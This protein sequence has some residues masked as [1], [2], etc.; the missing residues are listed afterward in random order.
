MVPVPNK[1]SEQNLA[2]SI[3]EAALFPESRPLI[4]GFDFCVT[5]YVGSGR[6][7]KTKSGGGG[8]GSGSVPQ[9]FRNAPDLIC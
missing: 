9:H 8:S 4:C 5:L 3:L 2:F 7:S 6:K 1:K